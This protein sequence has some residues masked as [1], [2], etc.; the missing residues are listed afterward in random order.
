MRV[1]G[2]ST[3]RGQSTY[4]KD[5]DNLVM[6]P[7]T[8][9]ERKVLGVETPSQALTQLNWGVSAAAKSI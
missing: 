2:T 5:Q 7:F 6:I 1:I 8:T 4:G 9:A 3:P